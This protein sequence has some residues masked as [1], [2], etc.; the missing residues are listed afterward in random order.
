MNI[1]K[2][3]LSFYLEKRRILETGPHAGK[4]HVKLCVTFIERVGNK[5]TWKQRHYKTGVYCKVTIFPKA[6]DWEKNNVPT[7]AIDARDLLRPIKKKAER[8]IETV[9]TQKEFE[10]HFLSGFSMDALAPHFEQ[11]IAEITNAKKISNTEKYATALRSFQKYFGEGVTFDMITPDSLQAY[12][13]WYVNQNRDKKGLKGKKSLTS[14]GI[15]CRNL[16]HIFKRAI[17]KGIIPAA[18]YPFGM[19]PL[20]VIPEGGNDNKKFLDTEEKDKFINWRHQ[21]DDIN[22]LHDYAKF[23][24]YASGINMADIARLKR[25]SVYKE[26][27]SIDRQKTKGRKKKSRK[28]IIP[29]HPAMSEIIN[30][31]GNR[32]SLNPTDYVFPILTLGMDEEAI[33]YRIRTLVNDVNDVLALI[34]KDLKFEIKPTSYTL[35][36]TFSFQFMQLG[37]TTDE[38]QDALAHWLY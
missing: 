22:R 30:S 38:L 17:K 26:Y 25:S 36:H 2:P 27:I 28:L 12:E 9:H 14:V 19:E 31:R 18:M 8:I 3:L 20:Y 7:E 13:D 29:M 1:E 21:N 34:A 32:L 11:K 4:A 6:I 15:N 35:R 24:Y 10:R 16:R 23:S 5:K 37:G 33:F